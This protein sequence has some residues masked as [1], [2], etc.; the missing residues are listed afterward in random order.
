MAAS[1]A[2]HAAAPAPAV[3]AFKFTLRKDMRRWTPSEQ[4]TLAQLLAKVAAMYELPEDT[5]TTLKYTDVDG[6]Q[7]PPPAR[8]P[9]SLPSR[10]LP[11][12]ASPP[13][14]FVLSLSRND[15][16][17]RSVR[18]RHVPVETRNARF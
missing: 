18:S 4:P 1:S 3:A 7:V 14:R 13:I 15:E 16:F 12:R 17:Q 2:S 8:A 9:D 5:K 6:D 11:A 10:S